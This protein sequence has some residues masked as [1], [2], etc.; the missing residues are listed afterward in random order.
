[1]DSLIT[2]WFYATFILAPAHRLTTPNTRIRSV[3]E[4][5]SQNPRFGLEYIQGYFNPGGDQGPKGLDPMGSS[6][7]TK[8][9]PQKTTHQDPPFRTHTH[10]RTRVTEAQTGH[11][12]SRHV[13]GPDRD[14]ESLEALMIE[15]S[16]DRTPPQTTNPR[17]RP[18]RPPGR[19]RLDESGFA[20]PAVL[21]LNSE[22]DP[23][24]FGQPRR[25]GSNPR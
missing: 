14:I 25:K 6:Q 10:I 3:C 21:N 18:P 9:F 24:P 19:T 1:M 8:S 11:L 2:K 4:A 7:E 23:W 12:I 13:I 5:P 17:R 16:L 22:P 20:R 15:A